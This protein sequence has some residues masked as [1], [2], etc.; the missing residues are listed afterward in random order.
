MKQVPWAWTIKARQSQI[1]FLWHY[2]PEDV[3]AKLF[4]LHR[5]GWQWFSDDISGYDQSVSDTHQRELL[6]HV[7][8]PLAG[9]EAARFKLAWKDIPLLGPPLDRSAEAFLYSKKGMTPSG[10][11]M[12]ALDGTLINFA[13]VLRCVARASGATLRATLDGLGHWWACLVQGDDTVLGVRSGFNLAQYAVES[14]ALGYKTKLLPGAVFLMHHITPET[15]DWAPLAARVFQQTVFNEYP[16]VSMAVEL[17]SWVAR[18]PGQFWMRNPWAPEIAQ[19][20]AG[21]PA[22]TRYGVGPTTASR[23]LAN[24][25]FVRDLERDLRVT[26]ARSDRFKSASLPRS[27]LSDAVA[28]L[29]DDR[30]EIDLPHVDPGQAKSA[31]LTLAH[32]LGTPEADRP[33]RLPSL[34]PDLDAY[35]AYIT[36]P[37]QEVDNEH[38]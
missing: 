6:K 32:Y 38:S 2:G 29:L 7:I 31:A 1:P 17:F 3:A 24:P 36:N 34:G 26:K 30:A 11:L 8:Q 16:G 25:E 22:F 33:G 35:L 9:E 14:E 19:A 21:A 18:T 5:R 27:G 12:T 28:A 15:G 10:D 20:L 23:A 37:D 4:A 13:R